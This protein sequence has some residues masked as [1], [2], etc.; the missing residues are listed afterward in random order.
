MQD[1]TD[2]TPQKR[3]PGRPRKH[4]V[5]TDAVS[6]LAGRTLG[7]PDASA[8]EKSLAAMVLASDPV[9]GPN[10]APEPRRRGQAEALAPQT[11][12]P[13]AEPDRPSEISPRELETLKREAWE[14]FDY[15]EPRGKQ[16]TMGRIWTFEPETRNHNTVVTFTLKRKGSEPLERVVSTAD[17]GR[18]GAREM[19]DMI[20]DDLNGLVP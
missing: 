20:V 12:A 9:E 1:M 10:D 8:E 6:S 3:K 5:P 13:T 19:S 18:D 15:Q 4:P 7:D 11:E 2:A 14:A 17:Y 16:D